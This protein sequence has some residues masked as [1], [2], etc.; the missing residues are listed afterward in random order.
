MENLNQN[1]DNLNQ[2][3]IFLEEIKK[4]SETISKIKNEV[5]KK[6][7]GQEHLI[8]NMLISLIAKWH[9]LLEWVPWLAKTLS[10]D[11]LSKTLDLWFNR[12]Q[13]TPDL[14]P[15]DL[16]WT[17]IYNSKTWEFWVKLWPIFNNFILADEI[18]RS[19]SKVQSALLE[20]MAEKQ[21]SIWWITYKIPEPFIVIAT[22]NPVEQS[23]TYKLPEA[24]LDRFLL[25]TIVN[26]PTREEE[27]E[28]YQ[29]SNNKE[30]INKVI[31]IEE[32]I[33]LQELASKI[34]VSKNIYNYVYD[35]INNSRDISL[36]WMSE[37]KELIEYWVS[38]RWWL[39]LISVSKVIAMINWRTFVIPEDIKSCAFDVLSHRF[40]LWYQAIAEWINSN[41]LLEKIIQKTNIR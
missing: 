37:Y 27:I 40:V 13:F 3:E 14:L 18:N 39:A 12:V 33:K 29:K 36:I 6:V 4:A 30:E 15:S 34:Y 11:T 23:W 8:E 35:I 26:Y 17:E 41:F 1:I 28:M 10:V 19:P 5:H 9:I 20:A 31:S 7:I 2:E 22:Q 16:V 32:L 38:P 25:K 24:Q 21:I